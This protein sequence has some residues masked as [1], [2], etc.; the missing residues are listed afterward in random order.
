LY[1]YIKPINHIPSPSSPAFTLSPLT[2]YPLTLYLSYSPDFGFLMYPCCECALLWSVQPCPLLSLTLSFPLLIIQH[3]SIHLCSTCTD[4]MYLNIIDFI[5]LIFFPLSQFHSV[6]PLLKMCSIFKLPYDHV[7]FCLYVYLFD[8]FS[9][10]ERKH[11]AFAFLNL[12]NFTLHN[13]LQLH[14]F[15]FEPHGGFITTWQ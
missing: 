4:T 9:T 10:Y 2:S 7:C 8:L 3:F 6:V 11:A 5:I 13:V 12:A 1:M 15:T 14:P